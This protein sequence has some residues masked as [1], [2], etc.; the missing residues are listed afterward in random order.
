MSPNLAY[1]VYSQNNVS[2]E[3]SEKLIQMLYEGILRFTSQAKR[4]IE[5]KDNEK[6]TYWI[7]RSV[8]IFSELLNSLDY[9]AGDVSHYLSGLYI[10][11]IK[12][13][14]DAN[15]NDDIEKLDQV[16][17]VTRELLEAWKEETKLEMAE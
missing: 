2:I 16:L 13:L 9:N 4:A 10:H 7:N 8:A 12:T 6:K 17:K 3:S 15:I 14:V 1:N 5:L 11:Q